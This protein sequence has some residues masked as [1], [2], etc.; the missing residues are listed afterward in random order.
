[1]A[2]P[3]THLR[4][5]DFYGIALIL[6]TLDVKEEVCTAERI[7]R[8]IINRLYYS[9]FHNLVLAFK[10]HVSSDKKEHIHK[11]LYEYLISEGKNTIA[12]YFN[13]MRET[14]VD[15]DYFLQKTIDSRVG[16]KMFWLHGKIAEQLEKD[17][18]F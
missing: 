15:A 17:A 5:P 16:D 14:R 7:T 12:E 3:A 10:F 11:E 13:R 8:S 18:P 9:I 6:R 4:F 2:W 1:M